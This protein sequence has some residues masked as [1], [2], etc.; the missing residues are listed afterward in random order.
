MSVFDYKSDLVQPGDPD[1]ISRL[2]WGGGP[3]SG[4]AGARRGVRLAAALRGADVDL[5]GRRTVGLGRPQCLH[6]L[7]PPWPRLL[8]NEVSGVR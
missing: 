7:G 5:L 2:T 1:G 6:R 3:S 4:D 8:P